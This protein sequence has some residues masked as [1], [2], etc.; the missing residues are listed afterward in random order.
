MWDIAEHKRGDQSFNIHRQPSSGRTGGIII[1]TTALTSVILSFKRIE[2]EGEIR[3]SMF[4][5]LL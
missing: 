5:L 4:D 3:L 2:K 1:K